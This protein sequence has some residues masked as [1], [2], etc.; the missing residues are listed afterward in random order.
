MLILTETKWKIVK[1]LAKGNKTQ[2]QIAKKLGIT[3]P[4][5]HRELN[6]LVREG[7]AVKLGKIKG[8]TRP[9]YEYSLKEFIFFTKAL[10]GEADA[11][12]LPINDELRIH[13]RI[14]SIPQQEFHSFVDLYRHI[15][16]TSVDFDFER[17][18]ESIAIFGSVARGEARKDS[19][20]D[21]LI[22]TRTNIDY[23]LETLNALIVEINKERKVFMGKIYSARDFK[24]SLKKGSKFIREIIKDMI[25]IYDPNNFLKGVKDEFKKGTI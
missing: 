4:A 6:G 3:L 5:V 10:D 18:I 7:Y 23:P 15:I 20:V 17:D 1:E 16:T 13:L 25:I 24:D 2:T 11:K 8:K 12:F 9:F 14:W 21:T 19:D 22:I